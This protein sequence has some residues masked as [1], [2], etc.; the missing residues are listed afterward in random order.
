MY[1]SP[2]LIAAT[3]SLL[4]LGLAADPLSFN[5]WPKEPLQPG[6]PITLTWSG[7]DPSQPVTILL[8]KGSSTQLKDV[9]AITDQGKDGTFTWTPDQDVKPGD[10]YAFQVKQG[11]EMNYT[12]LLKSSDKPLPEE[13]KDTTT[14]ATTGSTTATQTTDTTMATSSKPLISSSASGSATPSSSAAATATT[15]T[16]SA[17]TGTEVVNGKEPD[18]TGAV[19]T[20]AA[21]VSRSSV[22]WVMGVAG[23]LAYIV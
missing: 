6:K 23:L 15:T 18:S 22:Q 4:T 17:P 2:A 19:Q 16:E 7:G 9:K 10:T 8:R 21:S 12:A 5:S 3:A 11:Q 13:E 1:F 20:G 14:G